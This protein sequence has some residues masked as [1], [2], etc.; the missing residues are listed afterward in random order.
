MVNENIK[1]S[2]AFPTISQLFSDSWQTFTQSVLSLFIINILS[3]VIYL[4]LAAL[5]VVIFIISGI[6]SALLQKGLAGFTPDLLLSPNFL[7]TSAIL[8]AV[9]GVVFAIITAALQVATILI[10]DSKGKTSVAAAFKNS[11]RL[12]LPLFLVGLVTFFLIAGSFFV[13]ILPAILVGFLL[14]FTQLEIILNG[15]RGLEAIRRSVLLISKNFGAIFVRSILLWVL[16]FVVFLVINILKN[17]VTQDAQWMVSIF[18]YL[19]NIILGWF[20]LAYQIILYKHA[21]IGLENEKGKGI[22]WIWV[23]ALV[24]WLIAAAVAFGSYKFFSSQFFQKAVSTEMSQTGEMSAE[25]KIHYENSQKL[26]KQMRE[27]PNSGKTDAE[28]ISE[29]KK[30]NDENIAEIKKALEI[31]PNNPKLWYQLGSAY[32]WVSSSG[33]LEDG[34]AAYLK[35]EE[36]DPNNA[37]YINGVGDILIQMEKYEEAILH[38][39]KTL[40]LTD[41]SGFANLSVARAYANLKIYDS[42]REHYLKAIEIFTSENQSGN[43]DSYILQAKKELSNLPK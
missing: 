26:F 6:G 19:L 38:F 5:A 22:R 40:R 37:L 31:E 18:S 35:A 16:Y 11:L 20:A 41:K 24:G 32:T 30:L 17:L 43:Y 21:N 10:V 36:L 23:L 13:F 27:L 12:I 3:L 42:A 7:I 25:T 15:R 39:Q 8:I 4:L 9:F 28:L 14:G 34:L 1:T 33:T 2:S 29:T